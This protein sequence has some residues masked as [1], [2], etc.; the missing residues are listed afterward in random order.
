[1][2]GNS[3]PLP[4]KGHHIWQASQRLSRVWSFLLLS[5]ECYWLKLLY[6]CPGLR[7]R[8]EVLLGVSGC[9][10]LPVSRLAD[11]LCTTTSWQCPS[12]S[13]PQ[14]R[15]WL[16]LLPVLSGLLEKDTTL[17]WLSV[18]L[19]RHSFIWQ[20]S[21]TPTAFTGELVCA[22]SP[23]REAHRSLKDRFTGSVNV[24]VVFWI[25]KNH[26]N[27]LILCQIQQRLSKFQNSKFSKNTS[28]LCI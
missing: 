3:T 23:P 24:M 12:T 2:T 5:S 1:M 4:F 14:A 8:S 13:L 10:L 18:F 26:S 17:W 20:L 27:R 19:K 7:M 28:G 22:S 9:V 15:G 6:W 11:Y 21:L 25:K 16:L